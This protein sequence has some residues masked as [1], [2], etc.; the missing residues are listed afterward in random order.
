M[1]PTPASLSRA[2]ERSGVDA[3]VDL[4]HERLA[5]IGNIYLSLDI[6]VADP[7]CAP[8]TGAPV[9]G[10]LSSRQLLELTRGLIRHLPV[11]AMDIVE[12][13]PPLDPSGVTLFLGLQVIFE[14]L[15]VVAEKRQKSGRP[16]P[17]PQR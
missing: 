8:G 7:S 10:G 6:D 17:P 2:I 12:I 9:A 4:A 13:S 1:L 15:A 3:I 11:R 16:Q 5:G 14:I